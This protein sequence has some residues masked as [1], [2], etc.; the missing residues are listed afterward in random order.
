MFVS[1][2]FALPNYRNKINFLLFIN[3]DSDVFILDS[4]TIFSKFIKAEFPN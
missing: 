4:K 3:V 2:K 1:L